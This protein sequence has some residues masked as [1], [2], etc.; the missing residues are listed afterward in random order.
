M[1]EKKINIAQLDKE[2]RDKEMQEY[3]NNPDQKMPMMVPVLELGA[4]VI[5]PDKFR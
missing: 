1:S 2:L 3:V 4:N 5:W